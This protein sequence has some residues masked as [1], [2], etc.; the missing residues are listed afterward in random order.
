MIRV[1][2]LA[3]SRDVRTYDALDEIVV[4]ITRPTFHLTAVV[5]RGGMLIPRA[6]KAKAWDYLDDLGR[7]R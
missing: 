7:L 5:K 6:R 3:P 4:T 2:L 1:N